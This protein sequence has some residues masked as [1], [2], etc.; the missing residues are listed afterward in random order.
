MSRVFCV[1]GIDTD[2]GKTIVVGLLGRYLLERGC[3][4]ITQ[5]ICQTGCDG[6]AEDIVTHR[7]IMGM[8]LVELDRDRTTC[9]YVF[10]KPCSPHLAA[11]NEKSVILPQ[12]I[13]DSTN[14]LMSEYDYVVM[15]GAGGIHVP[16]TVNLLVADYLRQFDY[17]HLLVSSPRLGSINHT[18][19][20]LEAMVSRG[21]DVRGILYNRY[22][23]YDSDIAEDSKEIFLQAMKRMKLPEVVV[24]INNIHEE[25]CSTPDFSD[26]VQ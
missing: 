17:S 7:K 16:L 18:L 21:L 1:T 13:T 9:P 20:T 3:K 24:E 6:I 22:V 15:E 25:G 12:V 4:V 26:V 14:L 5:K 23:E 2:I 11:K 10:A 8:E 19:L